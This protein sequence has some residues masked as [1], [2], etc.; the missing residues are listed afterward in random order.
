MVGCRGLRNGSISDWR[1]ATPEEVVEVKKSEC[2][3]RLKA[4]KF[5]C[6]LCDKA[7]M[8]PLPNAL[9]HLADM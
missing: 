9:S 1:L 2:E 4:S 7:M 6:K 8:W 3:D 5:T